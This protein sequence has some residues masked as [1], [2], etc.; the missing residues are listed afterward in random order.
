MGILR[1]DF[2]TIHA[3]T[4]IC[5]PSAALSSAKRQPGEKLTANDNL[6]ASC[7][8]RRHESVRG[9]GRHGKAQPTPAA[10]AR[11]FCS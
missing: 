3:M 5:K 4:E 9:L 2:Q 10:N 11:R 8:A 6:Y 7:I 1:A